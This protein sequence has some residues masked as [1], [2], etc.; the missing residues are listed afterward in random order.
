MGDIYP[1][2]LISET[3]WKAWSRSLKPFYL[4]SFTALVAVHWRANLEGG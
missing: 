4:Y 2:W 1:R 3:R